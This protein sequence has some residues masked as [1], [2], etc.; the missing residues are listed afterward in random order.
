MF[1]MEAKYSEWNF[2]LR[3]ASICSRVRGLNGGLLLYY[4]FNKIVPGVGVF[5]FSIWKGKYAK[6]IGK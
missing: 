4:S 6:A 3:F 1:L 2:Q 5:S